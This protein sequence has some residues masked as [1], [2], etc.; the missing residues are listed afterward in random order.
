MWW[1]RNCRLYGRQDS[2]RKWVTVVHSLSVRHL[3]FSAFLSALS[4]ISVFTEAVL[5]GCV[6]CVCAIG[7]VL[8]VVQSLFGAWPACL[9]VCLSVC[10][11]VCFLGN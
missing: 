4:L 7:V 5:L 3:T 1:V 8:S 10:L 11:P 9:P 6:L 2:E